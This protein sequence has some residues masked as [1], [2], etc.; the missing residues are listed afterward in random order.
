MKRVILIVV[1]LVVL[2]AAL[3]FFMLLP[4]GQ[5]DQDTASSQMP[6][7]SWQGT[8][9]SVGDAGEQVSQAEDSQTQWESGSLQTIDSS[10][11]SALESSNPL[12]KA[13]QEHLNAG[14]SKSELDA[15]FMG[16]W[17]DEIDNAFQ[18][19]LG[20]CDEQQSVLLQ[21]AQDAWIIQNDEQQALYYNL[22]TKRIPDGQEREAAYYK[23]RLDYYRDRALTLYEYYCILKEDVVEI[24]YLFGE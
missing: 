16:Y 21:N 5:K 18:L 12:D 4:L 10:I 1:A 2:I 22:L 19:A 8:T 7:S 17:L 9:V 14:E 24:T 23:Y 11:R 20:A 6:A 3:V 15:S 13:Y